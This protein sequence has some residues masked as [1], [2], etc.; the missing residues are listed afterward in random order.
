MEA[1]ACLEDPQARLE[2]YSSLSR[3]WRLGVWEPPAMGVKLLMRF[4]DRFF[5]E[6]DGT[7]GRRTSLAWPE[8]GRTCFPLCRS[9]D[10]AA[11]LSF[12]AVSPAVL[13]QALLAQTRLPPGAWEHGW[14]WPSGWHFLPRHPPGKCIK[15]TGLSWWKAV[16]WALASRE[17]GLS[18][19]GLVLVDKD[20]TH[21]RW[22][23]ECSVCAWAAG[24]STPARLTVEAGGVGDGCSPREQTSEV[25]TH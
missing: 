20:Q 14:R 19:T 22:V 25:F 1:R 10:A 11:H 4:P 24:K 7:T 13:Q 8:E 21:R 5:L 6:S 2:R 9:L 17:E 12:R 23:Y 3:A 16:P 18:C 15:D